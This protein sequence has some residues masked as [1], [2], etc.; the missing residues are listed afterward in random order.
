MGKKI[1]IT[2]GLGYIGTELCKIYS[3]YSWNNKNRYAL[4][5][6]DTLLCGNMSS[7]LFIKLREDEGLVYNINCS[8]DNYSSLGLFRISL[9]TFGDTKSIMKCLNIV[10]DELADLIKNKIS[11]EELENS[12]NYIIGHTKIDLEDS[13]T[14]AMI[15][16]ENMLHKMDTV[17]NN[18]LVYTTDTYIAD[19][20][21]VTAVDVQNVA[22]ELFKYSKCNL[23]I[24]S[25]QIVKRNS[26]VGVVKKLC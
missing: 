16:S 11:K 2:G 4:D 7:R 24:L 8:S 1:V 25:K 18:K 23:A 21:K 3:G 6:I 12:I 9:G 14:V 20:K 5:I 10:V 15:Y 13:S 22:T 17:K 26:I 19:L